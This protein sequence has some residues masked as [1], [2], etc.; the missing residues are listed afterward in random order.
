MPLSLLLACTA[1]ASSAATAP[2][3]SFSAATASSDAT[4]PTTA[5]APTAC[6][7]NSTLLPA[8]QCD[9]W[10]AFYA[11]TNGTGWAFCSEAA[12]DPCSCC[13]WGGMCGR[14]GVTGPT[15]NAARTA[16]TSIVLPGGNLSG[17]LPAEIADWPE[18]AVFSM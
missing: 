9:A 12:T 5:A 16:V 15:C 1:S 8:A 13:G 17:T 14:G 2:T 7:G 11:A 18:L 6:T 4:A 10:Q 3:D